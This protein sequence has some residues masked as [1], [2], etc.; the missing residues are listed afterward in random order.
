MHLFV[1]RVTDAAGRLVGSAII[2]KP[3]IGMRTMSAML[4]ELDPGH[5]ERMQDWLDPPGG[6]PRFCSLTWKGRPSSL[7]AWR[8]ARIRTR[9]TSGASRRRLRDRRGRLGG[10]PCR[11]RRRRV[12]PRR[13]R[14]IGVGCRSRVHHRGPHATSGRRR[15]R[16]AERRGPGRR[17]APLWAPLGFHALR[18]QHRTRGRTE[19]TA[20][21]DEVNEA[22]RIEACATGGRALASKDLIE[23][24]DHDDATALGLDPLH[25]AYTALR[26][27]DTATE[28]ARR[29][30]PAIPVCDI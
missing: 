12:L 4:D 14:R 1:M 11:R 10:P 21:G 5:L 16:G 9:S 22:A 17:R 23:R 13:D 18:G 26:D 2:T 7:A 6:R 27:L 28:K 15:G 24:L 29:D 3:P 20:L 19:V 30:A 8:R 25:L